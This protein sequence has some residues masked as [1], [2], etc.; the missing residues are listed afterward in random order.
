MPRQGLAVGEGIILYFRR[1]G[2]PKAEVGG[3]ILL[4]FFDKDNVPAFFSNFQ[5]GTK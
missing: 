3:A 1:V 2:K 4:L 5:N